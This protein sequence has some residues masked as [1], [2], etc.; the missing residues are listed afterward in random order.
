MK[1]HIDGKEIKTKRPKTI[2]E[3]ARENKIDI[4]SLCDYSVLEPFTGCRLCIVEV[5]GIKG[6]VPSCSTVVE[7]GMKVRTNTPSIQ[8][9]RKNILELILTEHPSGCLICE[10]KN[11]CDEHKSTI[12]KVDEVTGCVLCPNNKRCDLQK[13]V[14]DVGL[15]QVSF[16]SVYRDFE[17][18]K[19]DP[20]FDRNYNLCIL[21]GRCVRVCRDVRGLSVIS[22]INR[23]ADTV[24]GTSLGKPLLDSGCQFCG[25]C[26]DVCPTGALTEKAIKYDDPSEQHKESVCP[27]CSIGCAVEFKFQKGKFLNV[28][29]SPASTANQGQACVR[30]R[31]VLRDILQSENR[32]HRPYLRKNQHLEEATWKEALDAVSQ[33]LKSYK[34][35]QIAVITSTQMSCEGLYVFNKFAEQLLKTD[36]INRKNL[37]S[38][39]SLIS[40]IS[41]KH[42]IAVPL[43]FKLDEIAEQDV[44]F[45]LDTPILE[46]NPV[47]WVR[48]WDALSRGAKLITAGPLGSFAD[49]FSSQ[50]LRINPGAEAFLLAGLSKQI[51]EKSKA[52]QFSSEKG[53]KDF[54]KSLDEFSFEKIEKKIGVSPDELKKAAQVLKKNKKTGLVLGTGFVSQPNS[55]LKVQSLLDLAFL[56]DSRIFPVSTECNARGWDVIQSEFSDN[57]KSLQSILQGLRKGSYKALITAAPVSLPLHKGI[58]F[59]VVLDSY[60]GQYWEE[61]DVVLPC[62]VLPETQGTIVNTEGRIQCLNSP[63]NVQEESKPDWRIISELAK[64]MGSKDFSYTREQDI[65]REMAQ[66]LPAFKDIDQIKTRRK[67]AV[68]LRPNTEIRKKMIPLDVSRDTQKTNAKY[69]FHLIVINCLDH[70]QSCVLSEEIVEFEMFRNSQWIKMNTG[71][72]QKY[73]LKQGD[74]VILESERGQVKG[75]AL[76]SNSFPQGIVT[77]FWLPQRHPEMMSWNSTPVKIARGK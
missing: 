75:T 43:L 36:H 31:F 20:F 55:E 62:S 19:D 68:F 37:F 58:E 30:G 67:K 25:A 10:E 1:I 17:I 64:K 56:T 53:F 16:P 49:R 12:R 13:V 61:A 14:Q 40:E 42:D 21:C 41:R 54:K 32:I 11:D 9:M 3:I 5:E 24:V 51:A 63:L 33:E 74:P 7:D 57:P 48:I 65:R 50:I 2:L 46:S 60:K 6:F 52:K 8:K 47:V 28:E 71:D 26:V 66:N 69:P 77:V 70:Y 73:D 39:V 72:A 44:L 45:L 15:E 27:L 38:P 22:F 29:V 59:L 23:G 35:E 34:P 4:P 76:L 18:Y